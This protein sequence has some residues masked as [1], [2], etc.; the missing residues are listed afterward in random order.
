M[1]K[2]PLGF[3]GS[4]LFLLLMICIPVHSL[5]FIQIDGGLLFI[6]NTDE[7][8]APSPLIPTLGLTFPII[9]HPFLNLES[10]FLLF[11][12]YY[13]Y[14]NER[15]TPVELEHRDFWVLGTIIDARFGFEIQITS[16]FSMGLNAC[17]AFLLRLP[18][19]LFDDVQEVYGSIWGYFYKQVRFFYPETELFA[20]FAILEKIGLKLS[21]R[22]YYPMFHL[23]DQENLPFL[24]Q[25][26]ISGLI[27]LVFNLN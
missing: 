14:E 1:V 3:T 20:Q 8:S 12:T 24:D 22:A 26:S 21:L 6:G 2:N 10:G 25:F 4:F 18:V 16:A 15:A 23:W 27:G 13:Q 5:S 19:P 7:E 9:D 17:L 11:S